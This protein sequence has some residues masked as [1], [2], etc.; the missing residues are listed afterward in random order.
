[1]PISRVKG[2]N[3]VLSTWCT[4]IMYKSQTTKILCESNKFRAQSLQFLFPTHKMCISVHVTS[5]MR[6]ITA[7]FT[8]PSM[9]VGTQYGTSFMFILLGPN[10]C[11]WLLLYS[12]FV[13]PPAAQDATPHTSDHRYPSI[14]M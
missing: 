4:K 11:R 7:D 5:R 13:D 3:Q 14:L 12:K 10:I 9:A 1:M 2:L 6:Q 8:S